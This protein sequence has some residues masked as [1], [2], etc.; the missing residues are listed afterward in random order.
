MRLTADSVNTIALGSPPIGRRGYAKE[1][2]DAFLSRI[3][4][5]LRGEDDLTAAEVHHV[6]FSRPLLSRHAY[7]ERDVDTV[8]DQA[9]EAL[10]HS[11]AHTEDYRIPQAR[12]EHEQA[13]PQAEPRETTPDSV[14]PPTA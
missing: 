14:Q 4:E 13:A 10:L 11:R 7:D 3:A 6:E 12:A 5:T 9:E 1:E 2:V 8:L